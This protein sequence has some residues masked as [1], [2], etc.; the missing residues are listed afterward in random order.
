MSILFAIILGIVFPQLSSLSWM[1]QFLLMVMLFYAFLDLNLRETNFPIQLLF[2]LVANVSIAMLSYF[3]LNT[4]DHTLALAA[5]ITAIAP[6]AISSTVIIGFL[7]GNIPFVSS[8]VVI[9]NIGIAIFVPIVLPFLAKTNEPV[10]TLQ[11]LQPVILTLFIPFILARFSLI[12]PRNGSKLIKNS[13]S[14]SFYIW[15]ATLIIVVA[16]AI[17]FIE[18]QATIKMDQI[19]SIALISLAICVLNFLVGHFIGGEKYSREASQALGQKNN[20]F[21]VWIALAFINPV[22]ALGPT[23]YIIY[24]NIYNSWQIIHFEKREKVPENVDA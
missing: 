15:L 14:A 20:S 16:K 3:L 7:K 21:V 23:F 13:K 10:S 12:L 19:L 1:I 5:F 11:I 6:T 18:N 22:V 4:I 9:T 24:H 8:A 2:V 17:D